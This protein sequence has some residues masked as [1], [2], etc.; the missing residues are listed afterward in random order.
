MFVA[1]ADGFSSALW[2]HALTGLCQGGTYTP[3]LA[4]INDNVKL[5]AARTG[6]GV[7]HR[8]LERGL[9]GRARHSPVWC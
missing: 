5:R 2:L 8:G 7:S 6:D 4:L 3:V 9:C 1:F